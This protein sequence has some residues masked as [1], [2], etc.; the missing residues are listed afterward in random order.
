MRVGQTSVI[1]FVSRFAGS[2]IGFF[3]IVYFSRKLGAAILGT[4]FLVVAIVGWT[5]NLSAAGV[6]TAIKKRMSEADSD[7]HGYLA[8]GMLIQALLLLVLGSG[9]LLLSN[10]VNVFIGQNVAV[11]VVGILC[12]ESTFSVIGSGLHGQHKV[13]LFAALDPV[14]QMLR[15]GIQVSL[16]VVGLG[17]TGLLY[18]KIAG[19]GISLLIATVFL[20]YRLVFPTYEQITSVLSY[21]KYAWVEGIRGQTFVYMDTLVLGFFVA[22]EF[23]GY[24]QVAFNIAAILALFGTSV[25]S[26]LFPEVSRADSVGDEEAVGTL[27][28]DALAFSGLLLIPGAVGAVLVGRDILQIYGP[29]FSVADTVLVILVLSQ[30]AFVYMTQ[31]LNVLNATNKPEIAFRINVFFAISNIV[32]NILL[33]TVFGWL[34]AAIASLTSAALGIILAYYAVRRS[35]DGFLPVRDW[36]SQILAAGI[37]GGCL[38]SILSADVMGL[39]SGPPI[40]EKVTIVAF[41]AAVYGGTLFLLSRRVRNVILANLSVR[42]HQ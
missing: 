27:L 35:I 37:M 20:S 32:L 33:I 16:V 17:L 15:T 29:A 28:N 8:A 2:I 19:T 25:S 38:L 18:G 4:Y 22:N 3:A 13:H 23:I 40:V 5:K 26:A 21:A 9:I 1:H 7:E 24:Y 30:L 36:G 41:G 10:Y 6:T 39:V 34:G 31:L 42:I 12:V 11:L 14:R